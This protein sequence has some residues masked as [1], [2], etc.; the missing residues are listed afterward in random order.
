VAKQ[1]M[2]SRNQNFWPRRPSQCFN[3][4]RCSFY[5]VCSR[6]GTLDDESQY[7]KATKKNEELSL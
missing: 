7:R 4:G 2:E 3:Y 6:M 5:P 1:I